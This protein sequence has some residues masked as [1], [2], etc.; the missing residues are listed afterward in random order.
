MQPGTS[1]TWGKMNGYVRSLI[2]LVYGRM[3]LAHAA[4]YRRLA[5][6]L[7][8][9]ARGRRAELA[10]AA[11]YRV[12]QMFVSGA[13]AASWQSR[14]SHARGPTWADKPETHRVVW[15][16]GLDERRVRIARIIALDPH[17]LPMRAALVSTR[18]RRPACA[19]VDPAVHNARLWLRRHPLRSYVGYASA[20]YSREYDE[21]HVCFRRLG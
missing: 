6:C 3:R 4:R 5:L 11:G 18:R 19:R 10:A 12:R 13:F 14:D 8:L 17:G 16:A 15:D 1:R 9:C 7:A 2:R 20:V 21:M